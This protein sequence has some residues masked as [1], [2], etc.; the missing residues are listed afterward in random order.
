MKRLFFILLSLNIYSCASP[1]KCPDVDGFNPVIDSGC[2]VRIKNVF[3][4]DKMS[5][6]IKEKINQ[7]QQFEYIWVPTEQKGSVTVP[8]HFE[9]KTVLGDDL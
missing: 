6:D 3:F 2:Q 1:K 8:A 5:A 9:I 4:A 7:G